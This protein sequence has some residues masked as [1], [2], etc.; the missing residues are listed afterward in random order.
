MIKKIIILTTIV[1]CVFLLL[2]PISYELAYRGKI[3]PGVKI[4]PLDVGNKTPAETERLFHSSFTTSQK[5]KIVNPQTKQNWAIS[6]QSIDFSLSPQSAIEKAYSLGRE[7]SLDKRLKEKVK[8]WHG[9]ITFP[10]DFTFNQEKLNTQIA[11]ISAAVF[12]PAVPPQVSWEKEINV[13]PGQPGQELDRRRLQQL[14]TQH[15]ARFDFQPIT[16]PFKITN[17]S[18][19]EK[20]IAD[21][22]KRAAALIGKTLYLNLGD[23]QNSHIIFQE[24]DI[25]PLLRFS[26]LEE[27]EAIREK[28]KLLAL[29]INEDP[30]EALFKFENGRVTAFKPSRT[31]KK[32]DEEKTR[33]LIKQAI[34]T[35]S[36]Q[37]NPSLAIDLPITSIPPKIT[38]ENVNNLGIRELLGEGVSFFVGSSLARKHNIQLASSRLNG[39]LIPPDQT[40]SFNQ[41]LGEVSQLTGYQK[42]YV[43]KN[44][45][46]VLGDGG[47]VCQVST[48]LFRAALNAGLPIVERWAHAYRVS[49]YEQKS[50]PGTDATVFS[51]SP[52]LKFKNDTGY[53]ILIQSR[54][55]PEESKLV[56][57]LY[58]TSDGRKASLSNFRLWDIVSPPPPKYIDDP[59]LPKGTVKQIEHAIAG[60][61]AAFDWQVTRNG[62]V[63]HEKTF[64]SLYQPWQAVYLRGTKE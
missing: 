60:A 25:I 64:Y 61:K 16:L 52:D 7:G 38:N 58:G 10:L 56:F 53:H 4:G 27:E 49:Y 54:Y 17:P 6:L 22:K 50:S 26:S 9:Q 63:I 39:I 23:D 28:V 24:K 34:E 33:A 57:S 32:L 45:Q 5:I 47:G 40:F 48:T 46:T 21:F 55:F 8:A 15:L 37:E 3:Y 19:S 18:P 43:I 30:Q 31:G 13:N 1:V 11:T 62:E 2:I 51:P 14:I 42:A 44:G 29:Q 20:E 35:L 36:Q 41:S 12:V 59:T